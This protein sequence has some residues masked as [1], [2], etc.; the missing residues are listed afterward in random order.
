M[1]VF[2]LLAAS[3]LALA[4]LVALA[5]DAADR[6]LIRKGMKEVEVVTRI[7]MPDREVFLQ[8][9]KGQPEEKEW[10]YLPAARDPQTIT[11]VTLKSGVVTEVLRRI[12]R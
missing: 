4:P 5:A 12:S 7:G 2:R 1:Q 8:N 10:S 9:T 3:A 11:T 6:S